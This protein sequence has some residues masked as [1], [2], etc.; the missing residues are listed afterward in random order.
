M[1]EANF[2]AWKRSHNE[3]VN[4]CKCKIP[5]PSPTDKNECFNCRGEIYIDYLTKVRHEYN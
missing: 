4:K 3:K 2:L 1:R 5:N